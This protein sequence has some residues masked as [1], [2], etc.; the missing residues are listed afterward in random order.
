[1]AE[2]RNRWPTKARREAKA[3]EIVERRSK[4]AEQSA[5]DKAKAKKDREERD[6]KDSKSAGES[7]LDKQKRKAEKLRKQLERAEQKVQDAMKA[8]MKRKRDDHDIGDD[9][10]DQVIA[11]VTGALDSDS[12]SDDSSEYTSATDSDDGEPEAQTS[13]H[14]GPVRVSQPA[15]KPILERQCKYF[16]TG[17]T[18]GKKGKCRFVHDQSVRDAALRDK[19]LNGG[20]MTLAQRLVQNDKEKDDLT[21]VKSI[22]YLFDKGGLDEPGGS[23]AYSNGQNG[24]N[25]FPQETQDEDHQMQ[26]YSSQ[27]DYQNQYMDSEV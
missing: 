7:K 1:M 12:D 13:R 18:C 25:G 6:S 22:K 15:R 16:S 24:N 23:S 11:K 8:G 10:V 26:G 20:R 21:V 5:R 14:N 9:I 17:G 19:E 27:G 3:V 4:A 2:R